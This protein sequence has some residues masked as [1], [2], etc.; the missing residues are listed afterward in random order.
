MLM[1]PLAPLMQLL[2]FC[3][4]GTKNS[5]ENRPAPQCVSAFSAAYQGTFLKIEINA[6]VMNISKLLF[7]GGLGPAGKTLIDVSRHA[8]AEAC[9]RG[10][11]TKARLI[12]IQ[13][14]CCETQASTSSRKL[15]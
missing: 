7:L 5:A 6:Y 15:T 10:F 13:V 4:F 2:K 12:L 9:V 14:F 11:R 1:P 3:S 8:T